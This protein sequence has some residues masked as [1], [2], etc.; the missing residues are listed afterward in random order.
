[1]TARDNGLQAGSYTRLAA[2]ATGSADDVLE[3][4]RQAGVAAYVVGAEPSVV[5]QLVL[6]VDSDATARANDV[7]RTRDISPP[8]Q[9][10]GPAH[11]RESF[12]DQGDTDPPPDEDAVWR[13][14]VA[15]FD[16]PAADKHW[17]S[18]ENVDEAPDED[19]QDGER[20]L[21]RIT[22]EQPVESR[23]DEHFVPPP[24]PPLPRPDSV[25]RWAWVAMLGGPVFLLLTALLGQ[26][27][28]DWIVVTAL[29]AFV[30]GFITLVARMKDRPPR[31][32]GP[33]DGAVI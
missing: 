16:A 20:V 11:A 33:D 4:L 28:A 27:V 15:A 23:D 32:S 13:S 24:P 21:R 3:S 1:M 9:S 7:L 31:D 18:S 22:P 14:L 12:A 17:P 29:A 25:T 19:G 2:L 8:P 5:H 26:Q 10:S 6:W 30:G